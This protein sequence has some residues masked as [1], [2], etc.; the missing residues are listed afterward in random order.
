VSTD[1][2]SVMGLAEAAPPDSK[3]L[4]F[5]CQACGYRVGILLPVELDVVSDFANAFSKKHRNCKREAP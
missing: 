4:P 2:N 5:L 1:K 3:F